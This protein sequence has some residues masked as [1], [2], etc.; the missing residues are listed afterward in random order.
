ME[1]RLQGEVVLFFLLL[2]RLS[3][4][5]WAGKGQPCRWGLR[6]GCLELER[7]STSLNTWAPPP[8]APSAVG[9]GRRLLPQPGNYIEALG[10]SPPTSHMKQFSGER[11]RTH[12]RSGCENLSLVDE[13]PS[14]E[15]GQLGDLGDESEGVPFGRSL[16]ERAPRLCGRRKRLP[17]AALLE[18]PSLYTVPAGPHFAPAAGGQF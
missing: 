13:V 18:V 8:L 16:G 4:G 1:G 2:R 17:T 6:R 5:W 9:G 12:L 7:E 3:G 15:R 11:E 14:T 10:I